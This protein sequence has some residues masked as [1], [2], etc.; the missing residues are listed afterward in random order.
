MA[1]EVQIAEDV[2]A[3]RMDAEEGGPIGVRIRGGFDGDERAASLAAGRVAA[4]GLG[5]RREGFQGRSGEQGRQ[6]EGRAEA[7]LDPGH[8]EDGEEGVA[9]A[10][11]EVVVNADRVRCRGARP[12]SPPGPL[13]RRSAAR[14]SRGP[15][16]VRLGQGLPVHLATGG[17]RQGRER[18]DRRR[19]H[20]LRELLA[21]GLAEGGDVGFAGDV[22]DQRGRSAFATT[23]ASRTPGRALSAASISPSSMR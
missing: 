15:A 14:R 11:E 10:F 21:Q 3:D 1:G 18:H 16:A 4:G 23:T 22:G 9:A 8:Q 7:L 2:A 6:G 19:E 13:R 17:E 12:R 5:E 20:E